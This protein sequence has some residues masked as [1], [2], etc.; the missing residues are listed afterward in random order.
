M[1][2][3]DMMGAINPGLLSEAVF[4]HEKARDCLM[5]MGITSENVA[6]DFKIT[7]EEMDKMAVESHMKAA[8]A[9]K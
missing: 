1:T 8:N 5:P 3:Y 6:K 2:N 9:Q 7:R 4:E